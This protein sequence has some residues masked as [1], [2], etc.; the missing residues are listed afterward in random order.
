MP[1]PE[2]SQLDRIEAKL[3]RVL[4][5]QGQLVGALSAFMTGGKPKLALYIARRLPG[6]RDGV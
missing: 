1:E 4:D 2:P 5:F 3:D 6:L